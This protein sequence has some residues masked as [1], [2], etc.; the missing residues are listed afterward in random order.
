MTTS[1]FTP[2]DIPEEYDS[3]PPAADV[4]DP[5][6]SCGRQIDTPY[7]GRG[8]RPTQCLDCKTKGGKSNAKRGPGTRGSNATLA[9]QATE[10]LWQINGIVAFV[11]MLA[12]LPLTADTIRE[13]ETA[14]REMAYAALLTDP[15]LCRSILKGGTQSGKLAL[16]MCYA[17]FLFPVGT[18]A[19]LELKRRKAERLAAQEEQERLF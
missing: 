14:F 8:R 15:A 10:A 13:R 16:V 5:C 19:S 1:L 9:E 4:E 6:K 17:M 11:A 3:V 12:Q 7:G 18:V 2:T